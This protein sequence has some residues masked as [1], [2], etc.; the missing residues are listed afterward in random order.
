MSA[1]PP[2]DGFDERE[3]PA[4]GRSV[5]LALAVHLVLFAILFFGVHWQSHEPK[6]MV[7]DLLGRMPAAACMSSLPKP[8]S[9]TA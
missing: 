5:V 3:E 8:S 7:V 9:A 2:F 6:A 1:V 4:L